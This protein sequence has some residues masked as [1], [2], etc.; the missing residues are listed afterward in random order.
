[1][2]DG[3]QRQKF[4]DAERQVSE[5]EAVESA[6]GQG[7]VQLVAFQ[8][9][10]AERAPAHREDTLLGCRTPVSMHKRQNLKKKNT[11]RKKHIITEIVLP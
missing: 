7:Q 6:P 2:Q 11:K 3:N 9:E 5:P 10:P 4:T 1:M 8:H